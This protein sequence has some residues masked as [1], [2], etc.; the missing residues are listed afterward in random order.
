MATVLVS[1]LLGVLVQS[2]P[3]LRAHLERRL[4][5]ERVAAGVQLGRELQA[6]AYCVDADVDTSLQAV[7]AALK[8]GA[9]SSGADVE[10]VAERA[11]P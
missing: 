6:G 9:G 7:I 5:L 10:G 4:P 11:I 2:C 8:G 1:I 3:T